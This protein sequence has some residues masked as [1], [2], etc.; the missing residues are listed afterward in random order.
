MFA[1]LMVHN[2]LPTSLFLGDANDFNAI[3]DELDIRDHI[4]TKICNFLRD[5]GGEFAFLV[6]NN[7]L[8]IQKKK[9]LIYKN[10][11]IRPEPKLRVLRGA[12]QLRAWF[13]LFPGRLKL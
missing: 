12:E 9:M 6:P 13:A 5:E 8:I 4:H 1:A 11:N 2:H 3:I 10:M 7:G